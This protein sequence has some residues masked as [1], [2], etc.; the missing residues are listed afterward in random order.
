MFRGYCRAALCIPLD[1]VACPPRLWDSGASPR[2][3]ISVSHAVVLAAFAHAGESRQPWPACLHL[4]A[5]GGVRERGAGAEKF[6]DRLRPADDGGAAAAAA[7]TIV[8]RTDQAA[9]RT[10]AARPRRAGAARHTLD[11]RQSRR[12]KPGDSERRAGGTHGRRRSARPHA[13]RRR[14]AR[15]IRRSSYA[16]TR[17]FSQITS[18]TTGRGLTALQRRCR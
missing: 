6:E 4:S 3:T 13:P 15:R 18:W 14:A 9:A 11:T 1:K 7:S 2:T 10:D 5:M 8:R 12:R 17:V 16:H